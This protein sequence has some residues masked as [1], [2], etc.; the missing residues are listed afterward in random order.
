MSVGSSIKKLVFRYTGMENYLRLMQRG[1]FLAYQMGF[2]KSNPEYAYH[3]FI[4][5]LISK[6][7]VIIDI[8]ANLGYYSILFA[9]WASEGKVYSVEP[10]GIYNRIFNEK[11]KRY[12]NITLY[13]YA[14]GTEEK[15]VELVSSPQTG[16]LKTGLPHVYDPGRDGAIE[17][18]EFRFEVKMKIASRL[19]GDLEK[20]NY[21]KCDIEGFE[22]IVLSDMKDI[23]ARHK[24]KVQ[25]EI[26]PDHQKELFDMFEELDYQPYKL[27]DN[28]LKLQDKE[29]ISIGGDFIFLPN[30]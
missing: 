26:W 15:N 5:S 28:K 27:I 3:Y 1:Y 2:L 25:V 21:I 30:K 8:G 4:K 13:P 18:Q 7:D 17:N 20:L 22:Y 29:N 11:A 9:Q 23:I 12:P 16:Y 10:I 14:L 19:F 24:P 6:N